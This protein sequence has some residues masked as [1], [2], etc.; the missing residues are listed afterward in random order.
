MEIKQAAIVGTL[1]SSDIQ[2]SIMPNPG[3]GL[4][5]QLQSVVKAQ[6]GDAIIATMTEVLESFGITEAFVDAADRGALDWVIRARMQAACCQA[7]GTRFDWKGED[8]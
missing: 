3:Q 4:E 7:T 1:E 8:Q 5:I 6:F 2:I